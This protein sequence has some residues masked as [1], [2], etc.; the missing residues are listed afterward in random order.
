MRRLHELIFIYTALPWYDRLELYILAYTRATIN[1]MHAPV[2]A[3]RLVG[4]TAGGGIALDRR[5]TEAAMHGTAIGGVIF[6]AI[7]TIVSVAKILL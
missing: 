2:V 3:Y 7:V 1:R 4:A 5:I 6:L